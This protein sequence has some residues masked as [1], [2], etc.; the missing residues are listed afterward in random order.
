MPWLETDVRDQRIQF[1]MAARRPGANI[2]AVC[3]AFGISRKTGYKWLEREAT[4]GS[5]AVLADRSRRPHSSPTR[6]DGVTTARVRALRQAFGWGGDKLACV[7]AA[8]GITLAPRTVDRIIQREG[9]TRELPVVGPAPT[10][11]EHAAANDLWQLDAKGPYPLAGGGR[12]HPLSIIDDHS[13]FAVGLAALPTVATATVEPALRACFE[14]YGVPRAMLMDH[15][16][17]W[18][19][20]ASHDGLTRLT[21]ALLKQGIRLVYGAIRHPQTQGKVE[22]FHRTLAEH[23]RWV[24]VPTTLRDFSRALTHFREEYNHVRPH[25]ALGMRPPAHRFVASRR[26]YQPQPPRWE[27]PAGLTVRRVQ[28]NGMVHYHA[29]QYYVSEALYGEEVACVP[30]PGADRVIV[31]YRHMIV[32]EWWLRSRRSVALLQPI[33]NEW[34]ANAAASTGHLVLPM[35]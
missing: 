9:L 2:S 3:R 30:L 6:T 24:G 8:E 13:R 19:S 22:R 28:Q 7:L 23:L 25:E 1:V 15:G 21:V 26:R 17:P 4:A 5:V 14:R 31:T 29:A 34:P 12:C 27:Y 32:R 33:K 10:R 18:W 35:P 20:T 11:F 16:S